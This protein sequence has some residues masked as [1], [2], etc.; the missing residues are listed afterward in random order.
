MQLALKSFA[1]K[2]ALTIAAVSQQVVLM[3][4][5]IKNVVNKHSRLQDDTSLTSMHICS[6]VVYTYVQYLMRTSNIDVYMCNR[7]QI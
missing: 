4:M 2:H 7:L 3:I 1:V 6:F 5:A